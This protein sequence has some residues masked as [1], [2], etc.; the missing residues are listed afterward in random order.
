MLQRLIQEMMPNIRWQNNVET[1]NL[2]K[3]ETCQKE[4]AE[5]GT[6]DSKYEDSAGLDRANDAEFYSGNFEESKK[7][8]DAI[9]S[10]DA[11]YIEFK[12]MIESENVNDAKSCWER[13]AESKIGKDFKS[14]NDAEYFD[15]EMEDGEIR[16]ASRW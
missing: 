15:S 1:E 3:S 2:K 9:S 4:G 11:N 5:Y 14:G 8:N 16:D 13:L 6:G 12:N 10:T 7:G